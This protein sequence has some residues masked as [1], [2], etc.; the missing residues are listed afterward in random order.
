M[1]AT[2]TATAITETTRE[3]T[4]AI[5]TVTEKEISELTAIMRATSQ[6]T[7]MMKT[8]SIKASRSKGQ[9]LLTHPSLLLIQ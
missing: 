8:P 9:G 1:M 7:T 4:T 6:E 5:E 2:A 3:G